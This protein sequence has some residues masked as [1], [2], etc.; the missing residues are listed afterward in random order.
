MNKICQLLGIKIPIIHEPLHTLTNGKMIASISETGALGIFGINSG[1]SIKPDATTGVSTPIPQQLGTIENRSILDAMQERN[2]MNEQI[3]EALARTFRPFGMEIASSCS[4]PQEDHTAMELVELM[5]KRRI[6]IALFEGFGKP[7]SKNWVDLLHF[8]GIKIMQVI[9]KIDDIKKVNEHGIDIIICKNR[10][11]LK[12]FVKASG[13]TPVLAGDDITNPNVLAD[14]LKKGAHGVFL[15]TVFSVTQ[16]SPISPEIKKQI[17]N[18]DKQNLVTFKM[19]S[20]QIYSLPGRLPNK[21]SEMYNHG[22]NTNDIF[23]VAKGYQGLINGMMYGNLEA[24]YTDI[25]ADI[26]HLNTCKSIAQAVNNI[27]NNIN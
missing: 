17:I 2:L 18:A 11:K 13:K 15:K 23:N 3:D 22:A 20:Y 25:A 19:N 16:E 8:N 27:S 1:Y 14:S 4:N 9:N 24:G 10:I 21:L 7:I 5:R 12:E 26:N 6:T